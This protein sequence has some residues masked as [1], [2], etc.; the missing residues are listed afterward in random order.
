MSPANTQVQHKYAGLVDALGLYVPLNAQIEEFLSGNNIT[1]I[2]KLFPGSLITTNDYLLLLVT[3]EVYARDG[4]VD[5]YAEKT[6]AS[7]PEK[8]D[9][10][11]RQYAT[12]KLCTITE[13]DGG[14]AL[15]KLIFGCKKF[16]VLV[17]GSLLVSK[18]HNEV[19]FDPPQCHKTVLESD[20]NF[21]SIFIRGVTINEMVGPEAF[22]RSLTTT[23]APTALFQTCRK[24]LQFESLLEAL[25]LFWSELW[26]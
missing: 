7:F 9:T 23:A 18:T 19:K 8:L 12:I 22:A 3:C 6:G 10:K 20:L 14:A 11:K 21:A 5:L 24:C 16:N 1:S 17:T 25:V 26:I 15:H 2:S 4:L 13:S